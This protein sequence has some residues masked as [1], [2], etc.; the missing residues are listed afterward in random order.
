MTQELCVFSDPEKPSEITV[1]RT[2]NKTIMN[3]SP[4]SHVT[5]GFNGLKEMLGTL[6][7]WIIHIQLVL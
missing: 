5:W 1:Q 6:S 4:W 3:L 2:G 7:F